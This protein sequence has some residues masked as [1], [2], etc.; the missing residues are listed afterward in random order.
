MRLAADGAAVSCGHEESAE[1]QTMLQPAKGP[2]GY[3]PGR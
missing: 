3:T 2:H 1:R